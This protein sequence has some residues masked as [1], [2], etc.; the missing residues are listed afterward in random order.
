MKDGE[1][2]PIGVQPTPW[3][4][5]RLGWRDFR[6]PSGVDIEDVTSW[7]GDNVSDYFIHSILSIISIR[8]AEDAALF[9]LTWPE[10]KLY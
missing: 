7:A 2:L 6:I 1:E 10:S 4:L 8:R 9:K 5:A 3:E